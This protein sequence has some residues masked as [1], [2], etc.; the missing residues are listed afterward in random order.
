MTDESVYRQRFEQISDLAKERDK[1]LAGWFRWIVAIAVGAL[2]VLIP[3]SK[4]K[5]MSPWE[6]GFFR[7]TCLFMGVGVVA[8]SIRLYAFHVGNRSLIDALIESFKALDNKPVSSSIPNWMMKCEIVGYV[9]L[10]LGVC[11][12]IAFACSQ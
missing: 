3:L 2:S 5:T 7:S 9:A 11:C 1:D 10:L 12:L 6:M 8:L 4:T